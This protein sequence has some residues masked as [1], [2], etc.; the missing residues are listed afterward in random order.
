[1]FKLLLQ[2]EA[3]HIFRIDFYLGLEKQQDGD[4]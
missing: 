2:L 3:V 4:E 1:M